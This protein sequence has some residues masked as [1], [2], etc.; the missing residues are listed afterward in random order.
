MTRQGTSRRNKTRQDKTR[1]DQTRQDK[2]RQDKTRQDKSMV[3]SNT[4]MIR[5]QKRDSMYLALNTTQH[6]TPLCVLLLCLLHDSDTKT[7]SQR[8]ATCARC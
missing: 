5:G 7:S 8:V 6:F 1:Q 2:T 4:A 3:G